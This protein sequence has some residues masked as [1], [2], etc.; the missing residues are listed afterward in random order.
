M[1]ELQVFKNPAFGSVR[2]MMIE[3]EPWLV[4]KDVAEAL[5]YAKPENA[6]AAHVDQEDKT[7]TLIQGTGSNYKSNAVLINESGLYSLVMSSKLPEAKKFKRWVTSE[8]LPAI[9]KTGGYLT[10]DKVEEALLNP[11]TIIQLAT[12]LKEERL[13]RAAAEKKIEAD[14]P[15][16]LFAGAVEASQTSTLIG[17][18]A[19]ILKQNGIETGQKRLFG[20]MRENGYLIKRKG[21]D[22]NMPTQRAMEMGLFEIKESVHLNSSGCNVIT[23]TPKLTGR[24][25]LFFTNKFLGGKKDGESAKNS[26]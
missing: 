6:I 16:V 13:A 14:A 25:Q 2:T 20:W 15:K 18:F 21:S 3:G 7:T 9:R 17:E 24:G 10:P 8:V 11:D 12:Q 5:G 4:G 1:N 19:K 26:I 23:K 22:Y